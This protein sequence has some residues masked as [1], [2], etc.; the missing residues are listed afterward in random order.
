MI[1]E[2][3]NSTFVTDQ[4]SPFDKSYDNEEE[5]PS[6]RKV[7]LSESETGPNKEQLGFNDFLSKRDLNQLHEE[8]KDEWHKESK[9]D[10]AEIKP[11]LKQESFEEEE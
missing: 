7:I 9:D 3:H 8:A 4:Y 10:T 5:S 2:Q 1:K 6:P 11:Y